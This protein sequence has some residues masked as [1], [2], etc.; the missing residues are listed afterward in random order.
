[1]SKKVL[2]DSNF[3]AD[4]I[5]KTGDYTRKRL[6]Y[7]MEIDSTKTSPS[8][9]NYRIKDKSIGL[10]EISNVDIGYAT[11]SIGVNGEY[12]GKRRPYISELEHNVSIMQ[13]SNNAVLVLNGGLF[14]YIPKTK[15]G[16]LLS[17]KEQIG[18]YYSLL[19]ELASEGKIVAI[20]RGTEEHKI[21]KNH[22][23]DVVGI[24]QD[25]L[26][27]KDK[28]CNEALINMTLQDDIIGDAKVGIRTINWHNTATTGA[29]VARKM[30]ERAVKRGGADIF[31]ARTTM[32]LYKTAIVSESNGN[33]KIS[34]PIYMISG[35]SYT[36]FRGAMTAGAEYN[37]IKD[38]ELP[39]NN[40]WYKIT[41]QENKD[42]SPNDR[43]YIV[44]CNPVNYTAH[45]INYQ[46]TDTLTAGIEE[47]ITAST[48]RFVEDIIAKYPGAMEAIRQGNREAIRNVLI[49]NKFI[50]KKNQSI[51]E[52]IAET[53]G[54][55]PD[56]HSSS[57][58]FLGSNSNPSKS[59][60]SKSDYKEIEK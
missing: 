38:S 4:D 29:Y 32:G 60:V 33:E 2:E 50:D 14:T 8:V 47:L 12:V 5:R 18:Y 53:N 26:G 44:R 27:L 1:M 3:N 58:E 22:K 13:E 34:K 46:G 19:K 10:N 41:V 17:Y 28:V 55:A 24:L 31:L 52:Y 39:P 57:I 25:S 23:I 43:P 54:T 6:L 59:N 11:N 15:N 36:P 40:F 48:D 56:T 42:A 45:H 21:L 37:S 7:N 20:L 16:E 35:G 51:K 9:L 30:E 49:A